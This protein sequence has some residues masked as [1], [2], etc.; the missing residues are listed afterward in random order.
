VFLRR[1][2]VVGLEPA[3]VPV[4]FWPLVAPLKS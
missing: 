4:K 3:I 2:K 1:V